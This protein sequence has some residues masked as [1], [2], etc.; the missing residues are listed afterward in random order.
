VTITEELLEW[1]SSGCGLKTGINARGHLFL[2][3]DKI[4]NTKKGLG[5]A[6]PARYADQAT[7]SIR[8]KLAL[9]SPTSGGRSAGIIRLWNKAT[10][11]VCFSFLLTV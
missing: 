7:L 6:H 2:L 9:T 1:K 10:E 11:F 4:V 5:N 3:L 8:K